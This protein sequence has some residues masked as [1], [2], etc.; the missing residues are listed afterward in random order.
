[1]GEADVRRALLSRLSKV[2]KYHV[3]TANALGFFVYALQE[4]GRY[5]DAEKLQREVIDI[6]KGLGYRDDSGQLVSAQLFL[7]N[8]L[9]MQRR[10][11]DA[12]R[13]YDQADRWTSNWEPARREATL[14]GPSRMIVSINQGNPETALEVAKRTYERAR[15]R[16]GDEALNTI[17]ARGFLAIALARNGK[18]EEA[19]RYFTDAIPKIINAGTGSGD[20]DSGS[21]A[22]AAEARLRFIL[23][24]Y[25]S[26]LSRNPQLSTSDAAAET[27]AYSDA[28]RGQSV[29][30]ALQA[31]S[32][33]SAAKNPELAQLVRVA[34]DSDKQLG[35]AIA[36]ENN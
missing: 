19:Y 34:Q 29:Q 1:E 11:D 3:D 8:L 27:F 2:G 14:S 9:S 18:R 4:Q 6:Y 13:I 21:T 26:L 35:A 32:V 17:F 33:R 31:S 20:A 16:S 15:A 28:A 23:E 12:G 10:Y 36:T 7:A 5:E 24:S 30:R 25:C 22:A